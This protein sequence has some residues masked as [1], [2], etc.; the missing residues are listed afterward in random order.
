[1]RWDETTPN[2]ARPLSEALALQQAAAA[3]G[4]DWP[5][6]APLWDKLDEE[7]RELR[8][9]VEGG[10]PREIRDEL[11]DLLFMLVNLCRHLEVLP[12]AALGSSNRKFVQRLSA[13]EAALDEQGRSLED[14]DMNELEAL[15]QRA[16]K[17]GAA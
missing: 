16:K 1:M 7:I 5:A 14:A 17:G 10:E 11:G 3:Q 8:A 12:E 2:A 9:A 4:F 13:V 15:W 6:L